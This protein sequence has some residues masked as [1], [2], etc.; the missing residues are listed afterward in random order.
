MLPSNWLGGSWLVGNFQR[1]G[2]A[3][4]TGHILYTK[5]IIDGGIQDEAYGANHGQTTDYES[6]WSLVA[7]MNGKIYAYDQ[8]YPDYGYYC[9]DLRSGEQIWYKNGTDNGIGQLTSEAIYSGLGGAGV[10]SGTTW[11]RPSFAQLFHYYGLNGAGVLSHLWMTYG[12]NWYMLDALT[13]DWILTLT[14]VP[15]G[16]GVTDQD[17]SILRYTYSASTGRYLCW[18]VTKSIGP[19]SP[20][21]TG[22]Q[23]WEPRQGAT[24]DALNDTTWYN[25]GPRAG[26]SPIDITDILPRSG[27]SMNVTGPTGLPSLSNVLQDANRVPKMLFHY[28]H[29]ATTEEIRVVAVR[30]DEHA[31]PYSPW[32]NKNTAPQQ[33]NLGFAVTKVMDKTF[34]DPI[35]GKNYS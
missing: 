16:T 31:A 14:N 5:P 17:G 2:T 28:S 13:G 27:Y 11:A 6:M 24:I 12:N 8:M 3:P 1:W 7:V 34:K 10:Y 20:T 33:T 9:L 23:Q 18:N 22:E 26:A 35:A 21:G 32:P 4:S 30:I 15:G 19:P 29:N 25:W